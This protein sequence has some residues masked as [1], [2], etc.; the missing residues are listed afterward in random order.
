MGAGPARCGA[1]EVAAPCCS[2]ARKA[3]EGAG[4][5]RS[6]TSSAQALPADFAAPQVAPP[7]FLD[8]AGAAAAEP[9]QTGATSS[10]AASSSLQGEQSYEQE[11][12]EAQARYTAALAA[13]EAEEK[14]ADPAVK[15]TPLESALLHGFGRQP[16]GAPAVPPSPG[17]QLA[18]R[19]GRMLGLQVCTGEQGSKSKALLD[20]A[21]QDSKE[22]GDV[23]S[24]AESAPV[25]DVRSGQGLG[26]AM[27]RG[28]SGL[29]NSLKVDV[30]SKSSPV[31]SMLHGKTRGQA[32]HCHRKIRYVD[33]VG[34]LYD[35]GAELMPSSHEGME[36]R[37]AQR[38]SDRMIVVIKSRAKSNSFGNKAEER[39]WRAS[40]EFMM[41]LSAASANVAKVYE[42]LEDAFCYYVIMEKVEGLDLFE[43]LAREGRLPT[44]DCKDLLRQLLEAVADMHD[45]GVIHKDLKLENVMVDRAPG[46]GHQVSSWISALSG[47]GF[48][49]SPASRR[50]T[51]EDTASPTR[52]KLIDFD[53][54][55][56]H[57][58]K[59]PK[60]K[61]V[62]GTDFYLPPEAYIG[63]YSFASDIFAIGVIAYR[64]ITGKF[65]FTDEVFKGQKGGDNYVGSPIMR[66]IS[67]RLMNFEI[68]YSKDPFPHEPEAKEF[69]MALLA[70]DEGARPSARDALRMPFL[71][72]PA[73]AA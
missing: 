41:E 29:S 45:R 22:R 25:Q 9:L 14:P 13:Q 69:C 40:M 64:L 11:R 72:T 38:L 24:G 65:P 23:G 8:P 58:P 30:S 71:Q 34:A 73:A 15:G 31:N 3:P 46:Q 60:A 21:R 1:C 18:S 28:L 66:R 51:R 67:E 54:C 17:S 48:A 50:S 32:R 10:A 53:T 42:V 57:S 43:T 59:S 39:E 55:E 36:V 56:E 62:V 27:R 35:I 20:A 63:H 68:D 19:R 44:W 37:H 7:R 4:A 5:G 16:E 70:K 12:D 47:A 2:I 49:S 52:V 33:D 26:L 6:T 61:V